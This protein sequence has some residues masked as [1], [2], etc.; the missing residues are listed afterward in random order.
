MVLLNSVIL[1]I[2]QNFQNVCFQYQYKP[3]T[4]ILHVKYNHSNDKQLLSS[5]RLR[6]LNIKILISLQL[7]RVLFWHSYLFQIINYITLQPYLVLIDSRTD[8]PINFSLEN[9]IPVLQCLE[10]SALQS[11]CAVCAVV[12]LERPFSVVTIS[13][14]Y[15]QLFQFPY[16]NVPAPVQTLHSQ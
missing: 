2:F 14:S 10:M 9:F 5:Y 7:G 1:G 16:F 15:S 11:R 13:A 4:F 3:Q 6:L 12:Q 8:F